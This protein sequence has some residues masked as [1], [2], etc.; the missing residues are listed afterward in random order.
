MSCVFCRVEYYLGDW[1]LGVCEGRGVGEK[2]GIGNM[3]NWGSV[4]FVVFMKALF[5]F[6]LWGC[7]DV[8]LGV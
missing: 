5:R 7:G 3:G 6:F 8:V 4:W 2:R 1:G